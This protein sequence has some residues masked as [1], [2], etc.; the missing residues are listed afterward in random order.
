MSRA[1]TC[2]Y[3]EL[4]P[5]VREVGQLKLSGPWEGAGRRENSSDSD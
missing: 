4:E 2:L 1:V 3:A 5:Q